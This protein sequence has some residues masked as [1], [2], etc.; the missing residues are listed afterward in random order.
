VSGVIATSRVVPYAKTPKLDPNV[1]WDASG[2]VGRLRKWA[3]TGEALDWEKLG[4]GFAWCAIGQKAALP[5][6]DVV[7]G[8]LTVS[9]AGCQSALRALNDSQCGVP[10]EDRRAVY[11]HLAKHLAEYGETAPALQLPEGV[12]VKDPRFDGYGAKAFDLSGGG[13][14]AVG[15][16]SPTDMA[17]INRLAL[18]ELQHS[19]VA[20]FDLRVCSNQVDRDSERFSEEVLEDFV[21]TLPGKSLLEGHDWG[22]VGIG[23]FF[24]AQLA[25]DGPVTWLMGRCYLDR[26]DAE[27]ATMIR[28]ME[29]GIAWADSIGFYAPDRVMVMGPDGTPLFSEY[30]RGPNGEKAETIEV[31]LVFLGAQYDA[32]VAKRAAA[33]VEKHARE[34]RRARQAMETPEGRRGFLG[35]FGKLVDRFFG[36]PDPTPKTTATPA[37]VPGGEDGSDRVAEQV[38]EDVVYDAETD[39]CVDLKTGE[40]VACPAGLIPAMEAA[41]AARAAKAA[42]G[43]DDVVYD[44]E[45]DQCIDLAT[46]DVVECP[47]GMRPNKEDR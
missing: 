7:D 18:K 11:E 40:V 32:A 45:R 44:A 38:S 17:A 35:A 37:D 9:L 1:A 2:A 14:K 4:L 36:T 42:K 46:G 33:G 19:E 28:R 8:E 16:P 43:S 20:V 13:I 24:A 22:P 25:E 15:E 23:R 47:A 31:S 6:H 10:A 41:K 30:R 26:Q 39:R 21:A 29:T 12:E 27:S 34:L 3:T 5:H